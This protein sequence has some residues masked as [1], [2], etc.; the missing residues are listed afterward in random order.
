MK[1]KIFKKI[2]NTNLIKFLYFIIIL[3]FIA[4]IIFLILFLYK[5]FYLTLKNIN[6]IYNLQNKS[7]IEN[8]DIDLFNKV[9][10]RLNKKAKRPLPNFNA[11]QNVF[12]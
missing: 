4:I 11:I 12:E 7:A 1:H 3:F 10:L 5:N 9:E 8:I 6:S 2:K